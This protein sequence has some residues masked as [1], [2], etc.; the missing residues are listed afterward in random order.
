[1]GIQMRSN[2]AGIVLVLALVAASAATAQENQEDEEIYGIDGW[3][4][5]LKNVPCQAFKQN[6]DKSWS[7]AATIVVQPGNLRMTG[8]TFKEGTAEA[9]MLDRRCA[10][11]KTNKQPGK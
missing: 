9:K 5:G 11:K 10:R 6:A 4:A 8:H 1:M 3:P 7:Q 2:A